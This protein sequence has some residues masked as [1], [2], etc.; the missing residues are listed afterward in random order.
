MG[1]HYRLHHC[2]IYHVTCWPIHIAFLH[3]MR[4]RRLCY[5]ACMGVKLNPP[6]SC[7]S[8]LFSLDNFYIKTEYVVR[9]RAAAIGIVNG[10]GNLGNLS[11][12]YYKP[13][14]NNFFRPRSL[15][16][17]RTLG[18][19]LG[20][21][22]TISQW[23]SLWGHLLSALFCPCVSPSTSLSDQISSRK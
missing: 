19:H 11:V 22:N 5:D 23:P 13:R 18:S 2:A 10:M 3:G 9:K 21:R 14:V 15:A 6:T 20:A 7:V 16:W 12:H 8:H 1:R 17:A 4:I